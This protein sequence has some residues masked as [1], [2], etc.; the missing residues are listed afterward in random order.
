MT[1]SLSNPSG[2]AAE[3][4][5]SLVND[6]GPRVLDD[7]TA[8]DNMLPD[9]FADL[10]R[11]RRIV[12]AAAGAGVGGRLTTQVGQGTPVS[13]AVANVSRILSEEYS[14]TPSAADWVVGTYARALGLA[15]ADPVPPAAATPGTGADNVWA[16]PDAPLAAPPV[17]SGPPA[18]SAPPVH[19]GPPVHSGPPAQ[20]APPVPSGPPA[21]QGPPAPGWPAQ[22]GP[23]SGAPGWP[24]QAGPVS[25]GPGWPQ[26]G[27]Q[28]AYPQPWPPQAPARPRRTWLIVLLI[29]APVLALLAGTGAFVAV[30]TLG[31][32]D[33][34]CVVGVWQ[35]TTETI[36]YTNPAQTVK[37]TGKGSMI[38]TFNEDGT[39]SMQTDQME[40][41]LGGG[42]S[43]TQTGKIT[44]R[45][46]RTGD[47]IDYTDA[48][49]QVTRTWKTPGQTD[50]SA[51][52][53]GGPLT[54]DTVTCRTAQLSATGG[55]ESTNEDGSKNTFTYRQ[56]F[57]RQ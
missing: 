33:P 3:H 53:D 9:L 12:E 39:G 7:R 31:K 2:D 56:E 20:S 46:A 6:F 14:L 43:Y 24:G 21:Y 57:L 55:G 32:K 23:A 36:V 4:L 35:L 1:D 19:P 27:Y 42:S 16:S 11:E 40:F 38:V 22:P 25:G 34:D 13:T 54:S 44:Y 50:Q 18:Q 15:P 10:P 29:A 28:P 51:T 17:H 49:G 37:Y 52:E 48:V 47:R 30:Q 45:W 26:Q 41:D 8:L 5:R